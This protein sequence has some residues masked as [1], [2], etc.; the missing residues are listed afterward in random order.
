MEKFTIELVF[1]ASEERFP[2]NKLSSF[3][4][5]LQEQLEL[6]VYWEVAIS[7]KSYASTYQNVTEG[8]CMSFDKNTSKSSIFLLSGARSLHFHYGYR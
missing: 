5:F 4:N 1:N 6:E 2:D 3:T 7:E 8:K